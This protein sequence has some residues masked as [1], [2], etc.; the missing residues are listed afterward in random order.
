MI[1]FTKNLK[2]T[3]VKW[4]L[5]HRAFS[6]EKMIHMDF[7]EEVPIDSHFLVR[8]LPVPKTEQE[9]YLLYQPPGLKF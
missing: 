1:L 4:V 9:V 7:L 3:S 6:R 5:G 2:F 8:E